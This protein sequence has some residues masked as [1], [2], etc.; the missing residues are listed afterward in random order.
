MNAGTSSTLGK[1]ARWYKLSLKRSL[2]RD[3]GATIEFRGHE[4][5]LDAFGVEMWVRFLQ[6]FVEMSLTHS[7]PVA[8]SE[9]AAPIYK[10]KSLLGSLRG[11]EPSLWYYYMKKIRA[12]KQ[13]T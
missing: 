4:G 6:S 13:E 1:M 9:K 3:N 2:E 7:S 11:F 12:W 10:I 8:F 5:T